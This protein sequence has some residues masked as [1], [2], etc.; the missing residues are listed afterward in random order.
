[1][2]RTPYTLMGCLALSTWLGA[3][4]STAPTWAPDAD[5]ARDDAYHRPAGDSAE[6]TWVPLVLRVCDVQ[7]LPSG[8]AAALPALS[9]IEL[10][11]E[12]GIS[13]TPISMG[14]IE[15]TR[16]Q[17]LQQ[18]L[19][20]AYCVSPAEAARFGESGGAAAWR[21]FSLEHHPERLPEASRAEFGVVRGAGGAPVDL[22]LR[23]PQE[24]CFQPTGGP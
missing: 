4:A 12:D 23:R 16:P 18:G 19:R 20:L 7:A 5:Q 6:C 13:P 2:K 22:A 24:L 8:W 3:C 9:T 11:V 15:V 21:V 17:A 10:H 1:M 14:V